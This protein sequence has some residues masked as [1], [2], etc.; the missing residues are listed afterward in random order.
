MQKNEKKKEQGRKEGKNVVCLVTTFGSVWKETIAHSDMLW[1]KKKR[2][3]ER[4]IVCTCAAK[5]KTTRVG[6][7]ESISVRLVDSM[8]NLDSERCL[9]RS[10]G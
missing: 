2:E 1:R 9:T 6:N 8:P 7:E 3:S 4:E 10:A 5:N